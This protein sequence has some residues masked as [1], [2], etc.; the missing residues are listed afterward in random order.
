MGGGVVT[1][2]L[3][4]DKRRVLDDYPTPAWAI[5]A[6]LPF[7]PV[8]GS[9][10]EPACGAGTVLGRLAYLHGAP[11]DSM[12]GLEINPVRAEEARAV[13]YRVTCA[14][15]LDPE[16]I[17]PDADLI[18]SNPPF[19]QAEA[20]C[21]KALAS[22]AQGGCVAMLLRLAFLE[23]AARFDFHAQHPVTSLHVF[24]SRPSFTGDGKSDSAA[25]AWF[26]WN[27]TAR[28]IHIIPPNE[29]K[30]GAK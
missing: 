9:V 15:A 21:R 25:Y 6:I 24:S 7:L 23:S 27:G 8:G 28:G 26:V 18:L 30:R 16:T 2:A 10:L 29:S 11:L 13:G 19:R 3:P 4:E 1:S 12:S 20:F 22:V 17:W 5:D 14:D